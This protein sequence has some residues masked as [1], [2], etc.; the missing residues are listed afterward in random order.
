MKLIS[1]SGVNN[2]TSINWTNTDDTASDYDTASESPP[3]LTRPLPKADDEDLIDLSENPAN[4]H[5][6]QMQE[7]YQYS[8]LDTSSPEP[9][10]AKP[11]FFNTKGVEK[12]SL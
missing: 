3:S 4:W 8:D 10:P 1:V 12:M 9:S 2:R 6:A 11:Q 7:A 5:S